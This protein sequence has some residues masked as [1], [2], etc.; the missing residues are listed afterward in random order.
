MANIRPEVLAFVRAVQEL[1][2]TE[3]ELS[4]EETDKIVKCLAKLDSYLQDGPGHLDAQD[5]P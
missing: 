2:S 1:A 3:A 5:H 4:E